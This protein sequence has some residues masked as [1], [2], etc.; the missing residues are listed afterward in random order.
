MPV[1]CARVVAAVSWLACIAN[2]AVTDAGSRPRGAGCASGACTAVF[3]TVFT[4][5]RFTSPVSEIE[6]LAHQRVRAILGISAAA[7]T[8]RHPERAVVC[9]YLMQ[10]AVAA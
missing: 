10:L 5:V 9:L 8:L 7:E 1:A 6:E 4:T 3:T 2:R